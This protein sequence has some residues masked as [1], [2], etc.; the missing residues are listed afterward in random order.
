MVLTADSNLSERVK[1]ILKTKGLTL[2]RVSEES[3]LKYGPSSESFIQHNFYHALKSPGFTPSLLQLCALSRIS[4]YR[5]YDWLAL[6]G[7]DL[8]K[9]PGIQVLLPSKRTF[10]LDSSLQDDNARI[11]WFHDIG[12]TPPAAGIVPL[13]RLLAH[14]ESRRL[15]R[16]TESSHSHSFFAK[17]GAEDALAFPDLL[18]GS[19]V[20]VN[21]SVPDPFKRIGQAPDHFFLIEHS[22]GFCC[23]RLYFSG[24]N[25]IHLLS[26][27]L[28]YARVGLEIPSEARI[29]GFVDLEIRHTWNGINP[30]VPVELARQWKPERIDRQQASFGGLLRAARKR[31]ALSLREAS[32]ISQRIADL[33]GDDRYFAAAG[34]L[35]D[36]ETH[37][38]PPRHIH[39]VMTLC[40]LYS[41]SFRDIL[42]ASRVEVDALGRDPIP[43]EAATTS[44][45]PKKL[46]AA[47]QRPC[48]DDDPVLRSLL[49]EFGEVPFFLRDSL[50]T[51]SGISKPSLRDVFH[52]R[53]ESMLRDSYLRGAAYLMV[54]RRRKAADRLRSAP[55]WRQPLYLLMT[56]QGQYICANCSLENGIL[57]VTRPDNVL[58]PER[59]RNH[60]DA[61]LIG[62]VIIVARRLQ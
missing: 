19:I 29:V 39:K 25:R 31:S 17:V 28:P 14:S 23:S 62:Q 3:A 10:I 21:S 46:S 41:I 7:F 12:S 26:T 30:S 61:E 13:S 53:P 47:D 1:S 60:D 8:G 52:V 32:M 18:P 20:R 27:Q 56:R 36:Y 58:P 24:H 4:G 50:V 42:S 44:S 11:P 33:L 35:S 5:L 9:I 37:S 51:L 54:N 6:F 15:G 16:L 43:T 45:E 38:S 22:G 59:F 55:L 40:L 34:S 2:H 57:I 49:N 48:D